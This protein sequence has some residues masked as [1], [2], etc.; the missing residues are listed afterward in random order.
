MI[1]KRTLKA[2]DGID[3]NLETC[4]K[5]GYFFKINDTICL[6][7]E[8]QNSNKYYFETYNG[9]TFEEVKNDFLNMSDK[10]SIIEFTGYSSI[11]EY[12]ENAILLSLV[13]DINCYNGYYINF[14]E[15]SDKYSYT[16]IVNICNNLSK[17]SE[18]K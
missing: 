17:K 3:A 8:V 11:S 14:Y 18:V 9:L 5:E 1:L 12:L 7:L 10:D 6:T 15:Y 16:E 4:I 2:F 13:S